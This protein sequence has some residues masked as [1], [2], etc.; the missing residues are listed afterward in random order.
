MKSRIKSVRTVLRTIVMFDNS[1]KRGSKIKG[2]SFCSTKYLK[3]HERWNQKLNTIYTSKYFNLIS[4]SS[5]MKLH[6][7]IW[8]S[9]KRIQKKKNFKEKKIEKL[10]AN[11]I[12]KHT[13]TWI[14]GKKRTI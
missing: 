3:Y 4:M 5:W 8:K 13:G 7:P 12:C 2:E 6:E 14:K 1:S 10:A 11:A 9:R